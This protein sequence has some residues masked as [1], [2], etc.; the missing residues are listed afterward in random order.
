MVNHSKWKRIATN[1]IRSREKKKEKGEQTIQQTT[2]TTITSIDFSM[3]NR[4]RKKEKSDNSNNYKNDRLVWFYLID[5]ILFLNLFCLVDGSVLEKFRVS[6]Y[7]FCAL[8]FYFNL[9][10]VFFVFCFIIIM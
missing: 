10:S 8:F 6:L 3:R 2:Y 1:I 4:S 9:A 5:Y 7:L